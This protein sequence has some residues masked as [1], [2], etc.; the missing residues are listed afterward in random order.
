MNIQEYRAAAAEVLYLCGC[1]ARGEAPEKQ[2]AQAMD[3]SAVN[4]VS[5][6]HSLSAVCAYSLR[7]AGIFSHDL[8]QALGKSLQKNA[9][10]DTERQRLFSFMEE[11]GVRHIALK[12]AVLKDLYPSMGLRQMSDNDVL[13]DGTHRTEIRDYM[14]GA[15]FTT[16]LFGSMVDVYKKEP[17]THFELHVSLFD[18]EFQDYYE[19][20]WEKLRPVP[21]TKAE[22][23]MTDEDFYIYMTAHEYKHHA[24]CGTGMR[25]LLDNYIFRRKKPDLDWGYI[26]GELKKLG[27]LDFDRLRRTTA[28]KAFTEEP[29][30]DDEQELLDRYI[31][32]GT[33]GSV[34]NRV[35]GGLKNKGKFHYI[36]GRIFMPMDELKAAYPFYYKH[37]ILLPV[38]LAKR[39]FWGLTSGRIQNEAKA[40]RRSKKG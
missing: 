24:L 29:L 4:A 1:A 38:L 12:G 13:F 23:M 36:L 6:A 34:Q 21:G 40:I 28:D 20:I 10:L 18:R 7:K 32:S 39:I 31:T 19:N 11:K 9:L 30:T 26:S 33:Y 5:A 25:S 35:D 3:L 2:R 15:G 8:T 37:K 22:L 14:T 27:I 16:E 17:S